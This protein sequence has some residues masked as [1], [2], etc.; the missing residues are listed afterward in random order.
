MKHRIIAALLVLA[1]LLSFL[2]TVHAAQGELT[3][4]VQDGHA[5]V[6]GTVEAPVGQ[7]VIPE[8][9]DGYPVTA[10]ANGAFIGS[11]ELISV[12]IQAKVD[13]L[14]RVFTDCL[15]LSEVILPE[16]LVRLEGT[17]RGC[18]QLAELTLPSTVRYLGSDTFADTALTQLVL[19]SGLRE[20]GDRCFRSTP[21]T[22]I[23][24]PNGLERIGSEA[25]GSRFEQDYLEMPASAVSISRDV[26]RTPGVSAKRQALSKS[27]WRMALRCAS[28]KG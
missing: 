22:A 9:I 4:T 16:G 26:F 6:T 5:T 21:L 3:Y 25:F 28:V 19:P 18:S 11:N 13:R 8:T 2:P 12:V 1:A 14:E 23:T 17:F 24:L 15:S 7:L 10:I 27:C 20:I